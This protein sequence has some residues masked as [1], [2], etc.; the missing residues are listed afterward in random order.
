LLVGFQAEETRGRKLLEGA[1]ELKMFG[2]YIPIKAKVAHLESLSAHAGQSEL[3]SW[4][5]DIKNVPEKV[6]LVHGEK[7][8]M[9]IYKDKIYEKYRWNCHIP[10]L[11]EIVEIPM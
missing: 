11:Y 3:L 1:K 2:K 10:E 8:T 5:G 6:F 7:E 4:M 9:G